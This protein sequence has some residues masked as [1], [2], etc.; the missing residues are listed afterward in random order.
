MAKD[1]SISMGARVIL[2][3]FNGTKYAPSDPERDEV[4]NYWL[5]VDHCG[6]VV[7]DEPSKYIDPDRVLVKFDM[8]VLSLGLHCHNEIPNSLWICRDDLD[9]C[10]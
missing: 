8:D 6:L 9:V 5:L 3:S 7:K 10:I 1:D 4:N 2:R